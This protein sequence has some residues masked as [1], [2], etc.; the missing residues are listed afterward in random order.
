MLQKPWQKNLQA[1]LKRLQKP[2]RP[3]R[4]AVLGIGHELYGDDAIAVLIEGGPYDAL[5]ADADLF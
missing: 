5:S 1:D 4:L 3:P 2:D